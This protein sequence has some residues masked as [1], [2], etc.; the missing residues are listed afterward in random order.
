MLLHLIFSYYRRSVNMVSFNFYNFHSLSLFF[1]ARHFDSQFPYQAFLKLP[2]C[3][4]A[5]VSSYNNKM[6]LNWSLHHQQLGLPLRWLNVLGHRDHTLSPKGW[7]LAPSIWHLASGT[8][9]LTLGRI[10]APGTCYTETEILKHSSFKSKQKQVVLFIFLFVV[11]LSEVERNKRIFS[12][13]SLSAV[14]FCKVQ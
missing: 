1:S 12:E 9:H 11:K 10:L 6:T 7:H 14:N 2:F 13:A 5:Q 3:H 8:W 4:F